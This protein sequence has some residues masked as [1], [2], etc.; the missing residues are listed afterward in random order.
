MINSFDLPTKHAPIGSASRHRIAPNIQHARTIR[1]GK[2]A[3]GGN[4]MSRRNIEAVQPLS[5]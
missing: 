1:R 2:G 3:G 5:R 4:F